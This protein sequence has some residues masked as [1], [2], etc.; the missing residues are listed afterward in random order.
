[1]KRFNSIKKSKDFKRVYE[2]RRSVAD[3]VLILFIDEN[4]EME[5]NRLGISV[6]KKVGNSV[7]R[8]T[9]TRRLREIWRQ[10]CYRLEKSYDIIVVCREK[11]REVDF[12]QLKKSFIKLCRKQ[13]L[14]KEQDDNTK[15]FDKNN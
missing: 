3:S 8:H 4:E 6:S 2:K 12:F 5:S 1:M 14:I 13:S 11:S 15:F 10:E 9:V 7:I